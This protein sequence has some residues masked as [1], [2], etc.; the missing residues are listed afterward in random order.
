MSQYLLRI[1]SWAGSAPGLFGPFVLD[2]EVGRS[3]SGFLVG[4]ESGPCPGLSPAQVL[5]AGD[6][7]LNYNAEAPR[8]AKHMSDSEAFRFAWRTAV[9]VSPQAIDTLQPTVQEQ[10]L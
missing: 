2:D 8:S 4:F 5:W 3:G 9:P 1:S 6:I 7:T 10:V